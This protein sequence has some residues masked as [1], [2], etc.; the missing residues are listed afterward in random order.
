MSLL[1]IGGG[2][3]GAAAAITALTAGVDVTFWTSRDFRIVPQRRATQTVWA[4][5]TLT[6]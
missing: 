2:P 5:A 6:V 3:A 1:V 4:R